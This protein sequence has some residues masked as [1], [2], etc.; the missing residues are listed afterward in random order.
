MAQINAGQVASVVTIAYQL[1]Q[2]IQ[3]L[4]CF[5]QNSQALIQNN[6]SYPVPGSTDLVTLT[7]QEQTDMLAGYTTLKNNLQTIFLTLP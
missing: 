1:E 2:Q 7:A 6:F 3:A 4:I 5:A